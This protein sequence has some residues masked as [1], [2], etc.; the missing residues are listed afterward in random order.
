M[1]SCAGGMTFPMAPDAALRAAYGEDARRTCAAVR[2]Q[3]EAH[4]AAPENG[5]KA[6]ELTLH[7]LK[8]AAAALEVGEG[9]ALCHA[10]EEL[11]RT[12]QDW[13]P[14]PAL[15]PALLQGVAE[16]EQQAWAFAAEEP[17]PPVSSLQ[18]SLMNQA[19]GERPFPPGAARWPEALVESVDDDLEALFEAHRAAPPVPSEAT[20]DLSVLEP[21]LRRQVE[22]VGEELNKAVAFET[23]LPALKLPKACLSDLRTLLGHLLRNALDHGL[24][25][26]EARRAAGKAAQGLVRLEG[27]REGPWLTLTLSDDGGGVDRVTLADKAQAA[28]LLKAEAALSLLDLLCLEGA[29]V[30]DQAS[31]HSGRGV[32]LAAVRQAVEGW[33]GELQV[34]TS[35]GQGTAFRFT[36]PLDS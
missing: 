24:E 6:L 2:E 11:L 15:L 3:L 29:S 5:R 4:L 35:A 10:L 20:D 18:K 28:G 36:V 33:G 19:L 8:G 7:G 26:P 21:Y 25:R 12:P 32:G 34:T 30:Q 22:A 14:F 16:L 13:V 9:G 23:V 27:K 31:L 17:V 1:P